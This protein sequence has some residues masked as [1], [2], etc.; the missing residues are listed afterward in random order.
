MD[1]TITIVVIIVVLV[2]FA[3]TGYYVDKKEQGTKKRVKKYR[4]HI[5]E[6]ME[7]EGFVVQNEELDKERSINA[8]I[9]ENQE[10]S[11]E[12]EY[13]EN[14]NIASTSLFDVKEVGSSNV[15]NEEELMIN[16]PS[17]MASENVSAY[18]TFVPVEE[19]PQ[20]EMSPAIEETI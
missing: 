12:P 5:L 2:L 18:D 6:K 15:Q 17:S 9:I 3:I 11:L 14:Q 19:L 1:L 16:E 4:K 10:V 13:M 20:E 7:N 8:P